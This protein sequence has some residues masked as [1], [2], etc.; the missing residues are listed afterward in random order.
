MITAMIVLSGVGMV[1][2]MVPYDWQITTF[3]AIW[4]LST[5][6]VFHFLLPL[7]LN[8]GLMQFTF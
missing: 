5:V 8:P 2:R 4:P 7:V 6:V 3:T 1:G